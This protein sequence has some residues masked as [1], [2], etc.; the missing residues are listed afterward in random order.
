MNGITRPQN[1]KIK[2]RGSPDLDIPH[3]D[4]TGLFIQQG[5]EFFFAHVEFVAQG[6]RIELNDEFAVSEENI[7]CAAG[8]RRAHQFLPGGNHRSFIHTPIEF[9]DFKQP[10]DGLLKRLFV[11]VSFL[12]CTRRLKG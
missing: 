12:Q 10:V 7:S 8:N 2:M 9:V 1:D 11:A 4:F 5:D 3:N 6:S